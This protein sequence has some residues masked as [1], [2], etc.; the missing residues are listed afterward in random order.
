MLR[1]VLLIV[2]RIVLLVIPRV[3]LVGKIGWAAFLVTAVPFVK[4]GLLVW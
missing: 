2:L 4:Y 1:V 3:A